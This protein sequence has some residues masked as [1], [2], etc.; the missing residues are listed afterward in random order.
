MPK[1]TIANEEMAKKKAKLLGKP[2][3]KSAGWRSWD[4]VEAI[5]A[6]GLPHSGEEDEMRRWKAPRIDQLLRY[7]NCLTLR[8]KWGM[9]NK[10]SLRKELD[11]MINEEAER[12]GLTS[13]QLEQKIKREWNIFCKLN[14]IEYDRM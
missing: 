3:F 4:E 6:M 13:E 9:I 11:K 8:S 12:E 5:R 2:M 14:R 1:I 7:K 10:T